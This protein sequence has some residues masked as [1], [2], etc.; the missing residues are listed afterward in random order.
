MPEIKVKATGTLHPT[1]DA[2][3]R[4]EQGLK[5]LATKEGVSLEVAKAVDPMSESL[6]ELKARCEALEKK[7]RGAG[8]KFFEGSSEAATRGIM[9]LGKVITAARRFSRDKVLPE[10]FQ[11]AQTEGT[12]TAGGVAVPTITY[13][14]VIQIVGEKSLMRQLCTVIPMSSDKMVLP[15]RNTVPA[16]EWPSEGA[17]A[18]DVSVTLKSAATSTLDSSCMTVL[19]SVSRE[20][21]EDNLISIESFLANTLAEAV[22]KEENLQLLIGTGTP[23]TGIQATGSVPVVWQGGSSSSTKNSFSKVAYDDIWNTQFAIDGDLIGETSN[24]AFVCTKAWF[25]YAYNIK[26]ANGYPIHA[27]AWAG[28]PYAQDARP[29]A[30]AGRP[31]QLAGA[32]AYLTK[33]G[34][35]ADGVT[36]VAAIYGDFKKAVMGDRRNLTVEWD[37]SIFFKE[38]K[39]AILLSER[40][41][42]LVCFANAFALLKTSTT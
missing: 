11:R 2:I 41:A 17:V 6:E 33:C 12:D 29:S 32:P 9:S 35:D 40:I 36:K 10:G 5:D 34:M 7:Y 42:F 37:D 23:F 8:D 3:E 25:Q 18:T 38:R 16:A 21:S 1:I 28:M 39:R 27:S 26:D 22:A 4:I 30:P 13:N 31:G 20:L 14:D 15:I 19:D 24:P